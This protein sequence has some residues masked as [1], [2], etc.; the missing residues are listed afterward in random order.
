[1]QNRVNYIDKPDY[2]QVYYTARIEAIS[3]ANVQSSFTATGLVLY[4]PERVLL[5][6]HTQLKT[7]M[8]P[9]LVL[10]LLI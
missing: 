3:L 6:W 10:Q 2:L 9:C 1:M 5:K 8:P 4:N 7:L